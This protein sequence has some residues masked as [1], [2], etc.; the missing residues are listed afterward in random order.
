[1]YQTQIN[2]RVRY[3]ETDQMGYVYYGNYAMYYE[4]GR[5]EALRKLGFSYKKLEA[6][7]VH[8]P[9]LSLHIDY[10]RPAHYDDLLGLVV[11]I[12]RMPQARICFRYELFREKELLS[13]GETI[14]AFV[15]AATGRPLRLPTALA[16]LLAPQFAQNKVA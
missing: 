4:I 11:C 9:V 13:K 12:P 16:Q 2:L 6:S 5:V 3:A 1:M 8:M 7:G 10:I 15:S 14:L